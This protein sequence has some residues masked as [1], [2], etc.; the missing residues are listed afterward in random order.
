MMVIFDGESRV[1]YVIGH[2]IALD[3][4]NSA[5]GEAVR[6]S[7]KVTMHARLEDRGDIIAYSSAMR[8]I[9]KVAEQLAG[10]DTTMLLTGESGVGKNVVASYIH[11]HSRRSGRAMVEVNCATL[12]EALLEAELFGYERGS[13][14][15]ALESGKCGLFEEADGGTSK[16][17]PH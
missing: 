7:H 4:L 16:V 15:G 8:N 12:P 5:Y 10:V 13:F 14:T 1:K 6:E 17:E 3:L 2:V 11:T 9:L